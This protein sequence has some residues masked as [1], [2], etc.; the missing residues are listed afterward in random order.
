VDQK[1]KFTLGRDNLTS[2]FVTF[3]HCKKLQFVA[4]ESLEENGEITCGHCDIPIMLRGSNGDWYYVS[5]KVF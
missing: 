1:S 2:C 4:N 3:T 5:N